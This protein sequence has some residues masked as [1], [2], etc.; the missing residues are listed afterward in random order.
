MEQTDR[1]KTKKDGELSVITSAKNLCSY[2]LTITDNSP[3]KFRFTLVIRLQNY[4]LSIVENL[5]LANEVYMGS[6]DKD[7]LREAIHSRRSYQKKAMVHMRILGYM[8]RVSMER[9][10]IL[11]KQ[12]EQIAKQLYECQSMLGGWIKSDLVITITTA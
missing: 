9:K 6:K 7:L 12:F 11:P 3:K 1:E 2:V 10:C 8:A 5:M 4:S